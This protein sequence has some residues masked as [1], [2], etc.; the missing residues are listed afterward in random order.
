MCQATQALGSCL[1]LS[2]PDEDYHQFIAADPAKAYEFVTACRCPFPD[3]DDSNEEDEDEDEDHD[4][5]ED[6]EEED[7]GAKEKRDKPAKVPCDGGEKCFCDKPLAEHPDHP[8][9]WSRAGRTHYVSNADH[10]N[11]IQNIILD[12]E[13]AYA[14]DDTKE[15]WAVDD[16][17]A[18]ADVLAHLLVKLFMNTL[19]YLERDDLLKPDSEIQNLGLMMGTWVSLR[20]ELRGYSLPQ[21]KS[22]S[23]LGPTKD[24][25]KWASHS[26]INQIAAYAKKYDIKLVGPRNLDQFPKKADANADLPVL[27]SNLYKAD[28]FGYARAYKAYKSQCGEVPSFMARFKRDKPCNQKLDGDSLDIT[29]WKPS[30][31]K[32]CHYV[33]K[34]PLTKK[35]I[36]ESKKGGIMSTA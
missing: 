35:Q 34:D 29:S 9:G 15:M 36:E 26:Y 5:E 2:Q 22:K 14:K 20:K 19:A 23:S 8:L 18:G 27:E 3:D 13:E 30:E 7:S 4:D 10:F 16:D 1:G 31:R 32:G 17:S 11:V 12:Y 21:S 25:K 33:K 24:K 6:N 28:V